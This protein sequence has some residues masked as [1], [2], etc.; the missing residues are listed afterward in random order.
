MNS[1]T[2]LAFVLLA[3]YSF[4][5]VPLTCV[6]GQNVLDLSSASRSDNK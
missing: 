2:L 4:L 6:E 5:S 1:L 3:Y